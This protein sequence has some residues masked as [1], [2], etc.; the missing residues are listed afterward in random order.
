MSLIQQ[1]ND[2][3]YTKQTIDEATQRWEQHLKENKSI[4][5]DSFEGMIAHT[6]TCPNGH[7]STSF[8]IFRI[9]TL[10]FPLKRPTSRRGGD[11]LLLADILDNFTQEEKLQCRCSQCGGSDNK[12]F[13]QKTS[14]FRFPSYLIIQ[15]GRFSSMV[16]GEGDDAQ[17]WSNKICTDVVFPVTGLDMTRRFPHAYARDPPPLYDLVA[18]A[19]HRGGVNGGHYYTY[20]KSA[21]GVWYRYDDNVVKEI[22]DVQLVSEFAYMLFYERRK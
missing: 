1:M 6:R 14:I 9:L 21:A 15:L 18:V 8:E 7:S 20:A 5:T 13:S 16:Q 4:I 12:A 2:C 22:K 17:W 11:K 3:D 10:Q 19:N